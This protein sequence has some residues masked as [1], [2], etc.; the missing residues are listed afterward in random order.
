MS[1][2]RRP[3]KLYIASL[4]LTVLGALL[5]SLAHT[6]LPGRD[7]APLA[8][9]LATLMTT[10]FLFPL[11]STPK[12]KLYLDTGV[13]IAATLLFAP[14]IA[15][16]IAGLGTA[17]A[18][19]IRRQPTVQALFNGAQTMLQALV[20]GLILAGTGGDIAAQGIGRPGQLLP[21]AAAGGAMYLVNTLA[22]ATIIGLQSGQAPLRT[23][24]RSVRGA[25]WVV[26]LAHWAQVA[27]GLQAAIVATA[28]SWALALL[29]LPAW[30]VHSALERH[31]QLQRQ[32]EAVLRTSETSLAT[33]QRMA[34]L[35]NWECEI[36]TGTVRW[37]DELYRIVGASPQGLVPTYETLLTAIHPAD[38]TALTQLTHETLHEGRPYSVDCRIV[39][40]D[41]AERVVHA[42]AEIL[43]DTA[44]K[45]QHIVG[46]VHDIT[47]RK[48][49]E[50][51]LAEAHRRLAA[52]REAE[53]RHLAR[54][55][56]D[57]A[58]QQ[59]LAIS[60]GLA[61]LSRDTYL[62]RD[63]RGAQDLGKPF[64]NGL[65]PGLD[66]A[67]QQVLQ[68]VA[69]LRALIR[70]LRPAGLDELGLPAALEGYVERLQQEAGA[71]APAID[72]DLDPE[73]SALPEPVALCLFRVAQEALRN[74]LRHAHA[75]R[76]TLSLHLSDGEAILEVQDD[77]CGFAVPARLGELTQGDHFGLVGMAERVGWA[78]GQ[79]AVRSQPGLG[80][81]I[82]A[83][84]PLAT[85]APQA[86][87]DARVGVADED[88]TA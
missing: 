44:G 25:G 61:A 2:L 83:R 28:D 55:L 78:S 43:R 60:Y 38:R 54:E 7:R 48:R 73:G 35:G 5:V 30:A 82:A 62:W 53:Q 32:T 67:R 17:L 34:Q 46:T 37:S 1:Q 81:T 87:R 16:A 3:A 31:V 58:V 57:G 26:Q 29:L 85:T 10:A 20:G 68:V 59:L 50:I 18:Q 14:G 56:H 76:V 71:I 86:L 47:E 39:R 79:F 69:Q 66:T 80:T 15:M 36:A 75:R 21:V 72:L 42:Q 41:G 77:G 45:P 22:V 74:I 84:L 40:P 11:P 65:A 4:V 27:L 49:M 6:G 63:T 12:K 13:I 64:G 52:S 9:V 88:H 24:W 51:E 33:A 23:W 8:L 19:A 70:G